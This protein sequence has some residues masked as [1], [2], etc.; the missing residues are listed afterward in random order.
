MTHVGACAGCSCDIGL[1]SARPVI[2]A[3]G[4]V[5][6][7]C[8]ACI[9]HGP[10]QREAPAPLLVAPAVVAREPRRSRFARLAMPIAGIGIAFAAMLSSAAVTVVEREPERVTANLPEPDLEPERVA[11]R[12]IEP[13]TV[14]AVHLDEA[15][16]SRT[17][18]TETLEQIDLDGLEDDRPSLRDWVHPVTGTDEKTPARSTRRF[19]AQRHGVSDP[20]KCGS[21]HCGLD[22]AGPRGRPV[23]AV[24]WGTVVR[25]E[26]SVNGRDGRSGRYVR[27]EHPEGVFTEYMHLDAIEAEIKVGD[28]VVAGQVLGTLGKSGIHS[29][30]Q[31]LHFGL[32]IQIDGTLRYV[33]PTPFLQRAEVVPIP[34][35]DELRLTPED[36]SNW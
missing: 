12:V 23:V 24:A 13:A 29:G 10:P 1:S 11:V 30:E 34:A 22:L 8:V 26:H 5:V 20:T 27:L 18:T 33:D 21:G 19:G 14:A 35:P 7:F 15:P 28:D 6:L 9:E 32:E 16:P 2:G 25:V 36:R 17:T 3:D 31:H 4:R